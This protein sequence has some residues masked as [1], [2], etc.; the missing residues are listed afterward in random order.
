[1]SAIFFPH[2][3]YAPRMRT[4]RSVAISGL[5]LLSLFGVAACKSPRSEPAPQASAQ[6]ASQ[7]SSAPPAA[8]SLEPPPVQ[9]SPSAP[10]PSD[11]LPAAP[12]P[13][14]PTESASAAPRASAAT[15]SSA[16]LAAGHGRD[17]GAD[18]VHGECAADADCRAWSDTCGGCTCRPLVKGAATP[19][20][21]RNQV[22][23]F[24]DPCRAKRA[25]CQGGSC[26]V[27]N[28]NAM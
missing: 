23:C 26:V 21:G 27:T 17:G 9:P 7:A 20:C 13:A 6:S 28:D 22:A 10:S 3:A 24:V 2:A 11:P 25:H 16:A 14:A 5:F 4:S 1:M 8:G 18:T 15:S 19:K 12:T